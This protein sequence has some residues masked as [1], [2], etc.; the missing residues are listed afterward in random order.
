M[1]NLEQKTAVVTGAA[2]GI[3]LALTEAFVAA[4]MSVVMADIEE[5]ALA[6][7]AARLTESG[8]RVLAVGC[9]VTVASSIESLAAEAASAFGLVQ[10]VCNN[11]G[12]APGGSLLEATASEWRW[13]I[14]VNVLG[15]ANGIRTF[16]PMLVEQGA[17]H[18]VNTASEAGLTSHPMLGM[19]CATK[20]AVVGLTEAL[21]HELSGTGVG[22]SC[23]CPELVRTQIFHSERNS[24]SR[25]EFAK[26]HAASMAP[27]REVI[28]SEGIAPEDVADAVVDAITSD[29][30]WVL[31][32]A[33]TID[34]AARRIADIRSGANPSN[35]FS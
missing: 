34:R 29:R 13:I 33:I 7:E 15:V 10:V 23:V 4:E 9:D 25:V 14:D 8:A 31:T 26:G 5:T 11:A 6:R 21:Y 22:V 16:A 28:E 19:Y 12:V 1:K 2:G 30:F 32:H 24:P 35:P 3:G 18:I 27:L 20:H 17:G